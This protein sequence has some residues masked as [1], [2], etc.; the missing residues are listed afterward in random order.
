MNSALRRGQ[1]AVELHVAAP[2]ASVWNVLV[3]LDAW[4]QWGP[5]SAARW[6]SPGH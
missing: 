3:D 2:P 6:T 1:P 5:V 4:P